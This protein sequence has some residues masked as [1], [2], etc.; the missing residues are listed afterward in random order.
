MLACYNNGGLILMHKIDR[1]A[2]LPRYGLLAFV[3]KT[4]FVSGAVCSACVP[5]WSALP[6]ASL[7][8]WALWDFLMTLVERT[9]YVL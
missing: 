4:C 1:R 3:F 9:Y 2:H 6:A 5:G 7:L 8:I